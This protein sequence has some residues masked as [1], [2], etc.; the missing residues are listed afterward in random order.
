MKKEKIEEIICDDAVIVA[1]LSLMGCQTTPFVDKGRVKFQV[2]GNI[3]EVISKLQ[4]NCNVKILDFVNRLRMVRTTI[5]T[6]KENR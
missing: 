1:Y 5:F 2:S 4:S 3:S 6:L